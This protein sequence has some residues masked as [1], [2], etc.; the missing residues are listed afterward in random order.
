MKKISVL[1]PTYN[2]AKSIEETLMSLINQTY[3]NWEHIIIDDG[4]TDNTK[5]I[6]EDFKNKYD[7]DNKINY[8]CRKQ[9]KSCTIEK[10]R[11]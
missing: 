6:I 7:K 5:S 1:T 2:D 9:S 11:Q 8:I 4:S 10:I 3:S